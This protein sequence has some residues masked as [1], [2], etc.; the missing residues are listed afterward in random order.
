MTRDYKKKDDPTS[1]NDSISWMLGGIALGL[2]IGL[3]MYFYSNNETSAAQATTQNPPNVATTQNTP[4]LTDNNLN[5]RISEASTETSETAT[6]PVETMIE[7]AREEQQK[8]KKAHF[9]YFAVLP[10]LELDVKVKPRDTGKSAATKDIPPVEFKK[11]AYVLQLASFKTR[12]Q[13]QTA[14]NRLKNKGI[15]ASIQK[16]IVRKK[17]W[18]RLYMGPAESAEMLKTWT[19]QVRK[20]GY[21]PIAVNIK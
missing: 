20:F 10:D 5:S 4:E 21:K 13:A 9:S 16:T 18:Y 12:K 1:A 19:Q 14:Q 6:D 8:E 17:T 7:N 3:G 11:G 2:L 15:A